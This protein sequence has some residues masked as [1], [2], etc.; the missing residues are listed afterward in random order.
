V[1]LEPRPT[2]GGTLFLLTEAFRSAGGV[3][4][5]NRDQLAAIAQCEPG[6]PLSALV[7][8]DRPSDLPAGWIGGRA[9]GCSRH[10][11]RFAAQAWCAVRRQ[12]PARVLLGHRNFLP[13][14]GLI[15]LA[16]PASEVW[17]VTY[18]IEA[19]PRLR[20]HERLCLSWVRRVFAISPQTAAAFERAGCHRT[21]ELWPCA[22]PSAWTLP[23]VEPPR[24]QAPY[25]LL[26]VSRLA[27]PERSKGLD[28]TL[29]AL[30]L[31]RRSGTPAELDIVGDGD[32]RGRL[33]ALVATEGLR[34]AVR[35]HGAADAAT[36]GALYG[37]ADLFVLPSGSEGFGLVYLEAMAHERPVVAADAGGTPFVVRPG[38]SGVLVPFG[39]AEA[40][41][42]A[43]SSLIADPHQ[44]RALGRSGRKFLLDNFTFQ[45][46]LERTA[47]LLRGP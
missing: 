1:D 25:R 30:A 16:S 18:G 34:A 11:W 40:L 19:L 37:R 42:G 14:V 15:T 21:I 6:L 23:E 45:H 28:F 46:L 33:E 35:F 43:L 8:N 9:T 13:L 26:S 4:T 3:Q 44:A 47:L 31:L 2:T 36:L 12:R 10:K 39:D 32:D 7:L 27:P 22:L 24:F 41:A 20:T 17:L 5:F 29:R 38:V